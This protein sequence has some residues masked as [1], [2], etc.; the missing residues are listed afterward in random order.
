MPSNGVTRSAEENSVG[1]T[2]DV[3][4]SSTSSKPQ[5]VLVFGR[6]GAGKS[7]VA[8]LLVTG[9]IKPV[10]FPSSNG[11]GGCTK[12]NKTETGRG[13]TVL[14][15]VGL[16][17]V[18]H[19]G[20]G[21]S[22]QMSADEMRNVAKSNMLEYLK[23]LKGDGGG[24]DKGYSHVIYVQKAGRLTAQD[25]LIWTIFEEI[26][27]GAEDG[28]VV[29][30]T[31]ADEEWLESN[32]NKI[33]EEMKKHPICVVDIPP[34]SRFIWEESKY[35][36]IRTT[37]LQKL[38]EKLED[39]FQKRNYKNV[40]PDI[41]KMDLPQLEEK[42][43]SILQKICWFISHVG[44]EGWE[45]AKTVIR[46]LIVYELLSLVDFRDLLDGM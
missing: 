18:L 15:T 37:S 11:V 45:F 24:D 40:V 8:N 26:F 29:L 16:G 25:G 14:D 31:K 20:K 42:S 46:S 19:S 28:F 9:D 17:E 30:F 22:S 33:V 2:S 3:A 10:L 4:E 13:Y 34:A 23:S 38:E 43:K 36:T 35:K 1:E 6:T 7:A 12:K 21:N 5:K 39:L 41:T 27:K 32:Q 44:R